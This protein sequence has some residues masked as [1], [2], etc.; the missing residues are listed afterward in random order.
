MGQV[1]ALG[2]REVGDECLSNLFTSEEDSSILTVLERPWAWV[3]D[4]PMFESCS[5]LTSSVALTD[6]LSFPEPQFP[7]L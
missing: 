6:S 2:P 3:S 7:Q 1:L 4:W 5:A